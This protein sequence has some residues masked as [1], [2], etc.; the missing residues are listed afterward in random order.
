MQLHITQE[1]QFESLHTPQAKAFFTLPLGR[2]YSV[3]SIP[4]NANEDKSFV[5]IVSKDGRKF[6]FTCKNYIESDEF[7]DRLKR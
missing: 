6:Q 7:K 4:S 2:I 5:E 3:D 1:G